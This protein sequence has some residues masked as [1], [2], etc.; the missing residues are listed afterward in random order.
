MA[1]Q[2]AG[3]EPQT[4]AESAPVQGAPAASGD[5]G[6]CEAAPSPN[7]VLPCFHSTYRMK[8]EPS[9]LQ[10]I[11]SLLLRTSQPPASHV[12]RAPDPPRIRRAVAIGV[13]GLFPAPYLRPMIGHPT[14]MSLRFAGF[15]ADAIR[16]WAA[17]HGCADC[18]VEKVALEGEGRIGDRVDNLWRLLLNWIDDIR[19]ADVVVAAHS[20]GVPVALMLLARLM[21]LAV[22]SPATTR[23]GDCAMAGVAL[24]PFADYRS[25][26]LMG[27]AAELWD[28][29]DP[30]SAN[31]RR[32]EDALRRVVNFGARVTFVGS[33]DDQVVPLESA[34]YSP[35]SHPYI[36]RAV[37]IDGRLH[38][39]DFIAHLIG[40]ALKLRNLGVSDHGLVRELS[41]PLAGSLY[42]GDGHSRLYFDPAVY[43]LALAHAL[44]TAPTPPPPPPPTPTSCRGS[45]AVCSRSA[46]SRRSSAPRRMT[47]CAASTTGGPPPRPSRT[48]STASRRCGPG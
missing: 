6:T 34:I 4:A 26:L 1:A 21:D 14:G 16:R 40:F 38:P 12:S 29:G 41:A 36:Y 43:D 2:Q 13:H 32:F 33:I 17:A 10:Q 28:F 46:S 42:S 5:S 23:V 44:E 15:C 35:A 20:Q 39:P 48:S 27:S 9:M 22:L 25:S 30:R 37:F 8:D 47:C 11:A 19:R 18:E 45:Y 7:L 31:A 3:A 24:G